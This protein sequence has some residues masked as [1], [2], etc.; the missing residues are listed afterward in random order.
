[1]RLS[2]SG[3]RGETNG[4]V[5]HISPDGKKVA[6]V[7]EGLDRPYGLELHENQLYVAAG[8][9][10]SRGSAPGLRNSRSTVSGVTVIQ[11]TAPVR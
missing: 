4:A 8:L 11:S 6:K 10:S 1:M 7:I 5:Y 3:D 9:R 2:D